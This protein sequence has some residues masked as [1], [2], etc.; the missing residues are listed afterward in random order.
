M[1]RAL[2]LG[3][4]YYYESGNPG[5]PLQILKDHGVNYIRLRVWVDPANGYNNEAKIVKFAPMVKAM[6]MK[7]LID[8]HYSDT[9]ADP[10]HQGKPAAWVDHNFSQLQ[11]DVFNHTYGVCNAL[12]SAGAAPDMVQIG[13][14]ITPGMLLPDGSTRDWTNLAALLKQGCNAVKSCD[15]TIQVMLHI[16]KGGDN[17]ASRA[18]FDNARSHGVSWDVIG[19]SYYSYWHGPIADMKTNVADLKSRYGKPVII[20]ETAYPFTL[21]ENDHEKNV[22]HSPDQLSPDFPATPAGQANNFRAVL[23]AAGSA[24]ATGVFYWEPTWTAVEGNGWD[25]ANPDSGDQWENQAL[26]DYEAKALPAMSAFKL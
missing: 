2:A 3:A 9:W 8:F 16:D 5:D 26:F 25:L 4:K 24:G 21:A 20:V 6:G 10:E 7:L 11:M 18:W 22:I 23:K 19:L 14:E 15:S 17:P 12:K 13:N 1:Q